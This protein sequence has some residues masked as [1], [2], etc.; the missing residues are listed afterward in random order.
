M[1]GLEFP[2]INEVIRWQNFFG[3]FNKIAL[4]ACLAGLIGTLIFVAAGAKDPLQAPKGVRNLAEIIV[5]F[6]EDTI[7]GTIGREGLVW[8]PWLV[9][10]FI[11]VY[12]CNLPGIIPIPRQD[13]SVTSKTSSSIRRATGLPAAGTARE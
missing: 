6:V 7:M 2:N 12:L 5:D 9:S 11:F 8:T 3:S 13:R 10:L 1:L 4:I